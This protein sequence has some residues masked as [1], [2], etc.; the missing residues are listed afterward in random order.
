[1]AKRLLVFLL[2]SLLTMGF[3][4]GE[5]IEAA[6]ASEILRLSYVPINNASDG[7]TFTMVSKL[8]VTN[9]G[10]TPIE[11]VMLSVC[12]TKNISLDAGSIFFD[13]I[14][15]GESRISENSFVVTHGC[16]QECSGE[17]ITWEIEY[18][19]ISGNTINEFISFY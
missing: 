1:M 14:S 5:F 9:I 16:S 2:L 4:G 8:R 6:E 3:T 17:E 13:S 10:K 11:D 19:D 18:T 7:T 12:H 15:A